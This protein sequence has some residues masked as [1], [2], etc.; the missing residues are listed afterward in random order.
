M[1]KRRPKGGRKHR[2][3]R[4][5]RNHPDWRSTKMT[6]NVTCFDPHDGVSGCMLPL[7]PAV[8]AV[9]DSLDGKTMRLYQVLNAF[10]PVGLGLPKPVRISVA[11]HAPNN[12]D[13]HG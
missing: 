6:E 1:A 10:T 5:S 11:N 12:R 3:G 4:S 13:G 2:A 8:K 7:P 9:A